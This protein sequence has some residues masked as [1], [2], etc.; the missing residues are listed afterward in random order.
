MSSVNITLGPV[1]SGHKGNKV[2]I[3]GEDITDKIRS[4][5][6][7]AGVDVVT[8]LTVNYVCNKTTKYD[9]TATVF[10]TCGLEE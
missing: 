9:G 4:F 7:S 8:T 1:L 3:N 5:T 6:L 10:H 2:E